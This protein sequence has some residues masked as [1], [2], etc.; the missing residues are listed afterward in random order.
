MPITQD[1]MLSLLEAGKDYRMGLRRAV[2]EVKAALDAYQRGSLEASHALVNLELMIS[3]DLLL[4]TPGAS[5][6]R[7]AIE[8]EHFRRT[9]RENERNKIKMRRKREALRD[10]NSP[11]PDSLIRSPGLGPDEEEAGLPAAFGPEVEV[12]AEDMNEDLL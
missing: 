12:E 6:A 7:L 3:E 5:Q 2:A 11:R 1:R 9:R 8:E 4:R 10:P